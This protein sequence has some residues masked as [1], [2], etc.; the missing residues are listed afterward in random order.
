MNN[1]MPEGAQE[2]QI[3]GVT[4]KVKKVTVNKDSFTGDFGEVTF[5]KPGTYTYSII[6]ETPVPT[7]AGMSYS[8]A[9]YTVTVTVT[10]QGDGT[11]K[12]EAVMTKVSGDDGITLAKGEEVAD[13]TAIFTNA[14]SAQSVSDGPRAQKV[15]TDKSGAKP[16]TDGMF[17]FKIKAVGSN[18]Q[19]APFPANSQA[20]N[21]G[22]HTMT[23][24]GSI[25]QFGQA[26]L[27]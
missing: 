18:A 27:Y 7:V 23:N 6:E 17:Q 15:Y 10:D 19:E 2:T 25:I 1:P 12:A 5:T 8:G 3:Q 20:D 14:F 24:T 4:A 13:K 11:L 21:E 16:L 22:W 9:D 26:A